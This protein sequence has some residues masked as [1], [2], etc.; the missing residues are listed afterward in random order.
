[1][2]KPVMFVSVTLPLLFALAGCVPHYRPIPVGTYVCASGDKSISVGKSDLRFHIRTNGGHGNMVFEGPYDYTVEE[3]G[4]I[5]ADI[6]TS[7][8]HVN[9]YKCRD[10]YWD[11]EA[12]VWANRCAG[13]EKVRFTRQ[14]PSP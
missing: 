6:Q 9:V 5:V 3:N 1:M 13:G 10:W 14:R 11:G 7:G 12:I 8:G 4:K 2:S